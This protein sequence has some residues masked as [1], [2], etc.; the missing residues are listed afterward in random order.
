MT[1]EPRGRPS[2]VTVAQLLVYVMIG[3]GFL[4]QAVRAF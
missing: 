1:D 4:V 3:V 2:W